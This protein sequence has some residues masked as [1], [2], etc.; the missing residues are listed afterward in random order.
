G[1]SAQ[2]VKQFSD[3]ILAQ[4]PAKLEEKI[5][6]LEIF[7]L[8][9]SSADGWKTE[10]IETTQKSSED[11]SEALN[12]RW[13]EMVRQYS[14]LR[15]IWQQQVSIKILIMDEWIKGHPFDEI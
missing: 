4:H 7:A 1:I 5:N 12:E 15:K 8:L 10:N 14:W 9:L 6:P 13:Q 3:W 11:I 2:T